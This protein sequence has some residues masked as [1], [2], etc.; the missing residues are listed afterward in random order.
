MMKVLSSLEV[1]YQMETMPLNQW[2]PLT[3]HCRKSLAKRLKEKS[4]K[5]EQKEHVRREKEKQG[6]KRK[7]ENGLNSKNQLLDSLCGFVSISNVVVEFVS[8]AVPTSTPATVAITIPRNVR[9][10]RK[11][12][13][14]MQLILNAATVILNKRCSYVVGYT[15]KTSLYF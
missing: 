6:S 4:V 11:L 3:T 5:Y 12:K 8:L 15:C 9:R 7:P 1:Q 13:Q 2:S 14:V 10:R